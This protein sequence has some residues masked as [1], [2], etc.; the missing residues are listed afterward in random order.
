MDKK[1]KITAIVLISLLVAV[2]GFVIVYWA[3]FGKDEV[4]AL[5]GRV[6]DFI[7]QPLPILGISLTAAAV[8]LFRFLS[9]SSWGKKAIEEQ[10][11][12]FERF[13]AEQERKEAEAKAEAERYRISLEKFVGEIKKGQ[14]VGESDLAQVE[15]YIRTLPFKGARDFRLEHKGKEESE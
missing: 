5:F 12:K 3:V 11:K 14:W 6:K 2:L 9:L 10:E 1:K 4:I 15:S 8:I 13:K 7:N